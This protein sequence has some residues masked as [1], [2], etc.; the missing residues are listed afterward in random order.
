MNEIIAELTRATE[1]QTESA[2]LALA[3]V[4]LPHSLT[5]YRQEQSGGGLPEDL[6]Q[7]VH[8]LQQENCI[9]QLKQDLWELKDAADIARETHEEITSLLE[10][11]KK[12]DREFREANP[13]FEG[14]DAGEVQRS[15][16]KPLSNYDKLLSSAQEGDS[17]LF[18]RLEQLDIEPKYNLL[19]FS[20]SQL[21]RLLPG[22]RGGPPDSSMVADTEYLSHLL[23]ELSALFQE[24]ANLMDLI[25][26]ELDSFDIVGAIKARID[27]T[28][29]SDRDLF[30]AMKHAQKAF[31]GMR[32]EIQANLEKQDEL[33]GT[34]FHENERFMDA[35]E[36]TTNSQSADSCIVMI[37]DAIEEIG[38]LS[39]HLKEGKD[40]YN[41][42]LPKLGELKHKVEEVSARLTV[43]RLEYSEKKGRVD[44]E[45][46]DEEMAKQLS[47]PR[48]TPAD[49]AADAASSPEAAASA[50]AASASS[51]ASP[52]PSAAAAAGSSSS[53]VNDENVARLVTMG[54]DSDKVT[55]ALEKHNNDMDKALNELLS[56]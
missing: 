3:E 33:L 14:H 4:H 26:K 53:N 44:Q 10:S 39:K 8:V 1:D 5:A 36:R 6:W 45:L 48:E 46:K 7:R 56:A 51:A 41:V 13:D 52:P 19:Q 2:R 20:K 42:V 28:R 43:E 18:R 37:E 22:A 54:F 38:R 47:E 21:D 11:D 31:D 27:P 55:A 50:P 9:I 12:S 17:V 49:S 15:F 24:R 34:I 16:W 40:F 32:Y 23:G 30:D 35:R 29:G 25:R